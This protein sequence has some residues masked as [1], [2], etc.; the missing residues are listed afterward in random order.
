VTARFGVLLALLS[1]SA[2][3]GLVLAADHLSSTTLTVLVLGGVGLVWLAKALPQL[4]CMLTRV[5]RSLTWWHWLWLAA[6]ASSQVFRIRET[7]AIVDAPIDAWALYRIGLVFV[8]AAVLFIRLRARSL[9][10][11]MTCGLVALLTSYSIV[12][13]ASTLWSVNPSWTLYKSCEFS[14]DVALLAALLTAVRTPEDYGRF[15]NW[16]WLIVGA[17]VL[18][19]W[20]GVALWPDQ[21]LVGGA[22]SLGPRLSGVLPTIDQNS[23]GEYGAVIAIVAITRLLL[24]PPAQRAI[25]AYSAFA[26]IG[27]ITLVQSQTRAAFIGFLLALCCVMLLSRRRTIVMAFPVVAIAIVALVA[28]SPLG[29]WVWTAFLRDDQPQGFDSISGR[30]PR[31]EAGWASFL[32]RPILGYGAYAAQRFAIGSANGDSELTDV[33]N[34]YLDVLTGTGVIGLLPIVAVVAG[35]WWFLVRGALTRRT[36]R[37]EHAVAVECA[38]VLAIQMARSVVSTKFVTHSTLLGLVVIGYAEFLRRREKPSAKRNIA[39]ASESLE[40]GPRLARP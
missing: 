16:I 19:V 38:A 7:D 14:V 6:I 37:L 40:W 3:I 36:D 35:A 29:D 30:L 5:C 39:I 20:A 8:V 31:W 33:L 15:L 9:A 10:A 32:D 34:T 12:A 1:F 25:A 28:F 13:V 26:A 4:M 22:A 21:A 23:V 27:L 11:S 24:R 2:G 17:L 18:T